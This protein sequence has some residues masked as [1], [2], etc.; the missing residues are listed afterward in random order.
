GICH[1]HFASKFSSSVRVRAGVKANVVPDLAVAELPLSPEEVAP[2][3]HDL[4]VT[5][6]PTADGCRITIRGRSAHASTPDL[7]ENALQAMLL[8]LNRLPLPREDAKTVKLL[9]SLF[10]KEV[11]GESLGVDFTDLSGRTTCNV[12]ILDWDAEGVKDFCLD[13]R[14]PLGLNIEQTAAKIVT[15]LEPG[16]FALTGSHS[17]LGH[18][19]DAESELVQ[20][21]LKVYRERTGEADPKPLAIGGGTYARCIP[22]AVAFG[23]ERPGLDNRIH[24]VDEFIPLDNLLDD[25]CMMA[26]A[27]LSLACE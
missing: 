17:Q 14:L 22:N 20:K 1:L 19:V 10:G 12:A 5:C 27:I 7:G 9:Y 16:G 18:A 23:C 26:D 25:A 4:P 13:L 6:E 15:A 3:V 24:Q 8:L 11:H 21:L 2:K